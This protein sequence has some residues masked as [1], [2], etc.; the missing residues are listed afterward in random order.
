MA[1]ARLA[2]SVALVLTACGDDGGAL[3]DAAP[4]PDASAP[5]APCAEP[6]GAGTQHTGELM[7]DETWTAAGSPH[8]VSTFDV[9][10][11]HGHTLTI[12]ACAVVRVQPGRSIIIGAFA[13]SDGTGTLIAHGVRQPATATAAEV[14]RPVRVLS[15]SPSAWWGSLQVLATGSADLSVVVLDRGGDPAQSQGG[16]G[17]LLMRGDDNRLA[18]VRNVRA[19]HLTVSGSAT[20]AINARSSAGF[21]ADSSDITITGAGSQGAIGGG[22]DSRYAMYIEAPAIQTIPPGTAI[23]ASTR[24][25]I[26]AFA[27]FTVTVDERFPAVGVPY[28]IR[29]RFYMEP[30]TMGNPIT[31]SI[32][33]GVTLKLGGPL[34]SNP[35]IKLGSGS[36]PTNNFPVRLIA[37]G[38][39]T[40]PIKITSGAAVPA[41][42]DWATID[43]QGGPSGGNIMSNVIVEYGGGNAAT[44]GF[45]CGPG[46]NSSLLLITD[47]RP[48]NAFIQGSTFAH[49]AS[50]GIVSGWASDLSGPDFRAGN[51]FTDIASSCQISL[52]KSAAGVCPGNDGVPDCY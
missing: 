49:S 21:T 14:T 1:H 46:D 3:P 34:A 16:G 40:A 48:D 32:D 37:A 50:G 6:T 18:P 24:N 2:L 33:A 5:L 4:L 7:A 30:T 52:P 51:T 28:Q 12:E 36:G 31:L 26:L 23:S 20:Y 41:P 10:V 15:D 42:G 9:V 8:I 11:R 19:Q 44:N 39:P 38:T 43:W 47:W 29:D 27:P 35:S 13:T 17:A 45:G 25:E 22:E